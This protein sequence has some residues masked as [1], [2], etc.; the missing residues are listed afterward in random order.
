MEWFPEIHLMTV[1]P[2]YSLMA[3]AVRPKH[4]DSG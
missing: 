2:I 3:E 1:A 4:V